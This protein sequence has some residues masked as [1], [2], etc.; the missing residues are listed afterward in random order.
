MA[1]VAV[2]EVQ[3]GCNEVLAAVRHGMAVGASALRGGSFDMVGA[4]FE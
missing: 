4:A 2:V 3:L 1:A